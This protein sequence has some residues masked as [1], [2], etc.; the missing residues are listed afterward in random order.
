MKFV[1]SRWSSDYSRV[2]FLILSLPL[3][4]FEKQKYFQNEPKYIGVNSRNNLPKI[5]DAAY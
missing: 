1:I 4:N 3:N 5:K 2:R